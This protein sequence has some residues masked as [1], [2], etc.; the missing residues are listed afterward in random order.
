MSAPVVVKYTYGH[1]ID[2]ASRARPGVTAIPAGG[3][4]L[5]RYT[6]DL[7]DH[8]PLYTVRLLRLPT[9]LFLRSREHHDELVREFT[10]MAIRESE[11]QL[12][13]RPLPP[14]LHELVD[15]LGR[16]YGA[17]AERADMERD[18][19]VE[20]GDATVDLTYHVPASIAADLIGV[21]ALM[22][23]AD[24]FCRLERLLTL[25]RD[26]TMVAFTHWYNREFLRQIDGLEPEPWAGPLA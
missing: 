9:A 13:A 21:T 11:Q 10:L 18:A 1:A 3:P 12:P 25:P 15:L 17:S 2:V 19:A 16:R 6:P 24:E 26:P 4:R 14:R 8:G 20:R 23:D 22:D 5:G 7:P